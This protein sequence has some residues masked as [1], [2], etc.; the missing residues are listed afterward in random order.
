MAAAVKGLRVI[1]GTEPNGPRSQ[2][3]RVWTGARNSDVYIGARPVAGEV[4]V[5]LH[6]SGKWRFAFTEKHQQ[7]PAPLI[8]LEEDRAKHKWDRPPE[9]APGLTRAFIIIVPASELRAPKAPDPLVKP[10]HWLEPPPE[11]HQVEIDLFLSAHP[12]KDDSWPGKNAMGTEFLYRQGLPNGEVLYVVS[13]IAETASEVQQRTNAYKEAGLK[14]G[15][16]RYMEETGAEQLR[17]V[18]FGTPAP[19]AAPDLQGVCSFT[20]IALP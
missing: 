10:A 18:M 6:E 4:R 7:G 19:D 15:L 16:D 11:G 1:V 9:F 5:S 3:W 2:L 8:G 13:H 14:A 12:A 20:D 17:G